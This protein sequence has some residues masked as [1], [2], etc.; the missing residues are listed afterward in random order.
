TTPG[1]LISIGVFIGYLAGHPPGV[2]LAS[3]LC[4][5][6]WLFLPSFVLVLAGGPPPPPVTALPGGA[7][8]PGGGDPGG[9]A[10]AAG[11][12]VGRGRVPR[13]EAGLGDAGARRGGVRGSRRWRK[14]GERRLC[15][16]RRRRGRSRSRAARRLRQGKRGRRRRRSAMHPRQSGS[17]GLRPSRAL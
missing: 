1:P 17:R 14:A 3:A 13:R 5:G 12:F 2:G 8:V 10:P 6:F 16:A 4:A 15:G 11:G 9:P 7:P